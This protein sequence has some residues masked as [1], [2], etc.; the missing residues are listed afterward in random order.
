MA[1]KCS[2]VRVGDGGG[3]KRGKVG[4]EQGIRGVAR[5]GGASAVRCA[6]SGRAGYA[7]AARGGAEVWRRGAV[8]CVKQC[9]R[10]IR[11]VAWRCKCRCGGE[12]TAITTLDHCHSGEMGIKN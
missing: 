2:A 9:V 8:Q 5:R 11:G 12:K 3:A 7:V 10:E 1:G 4:A 6:W